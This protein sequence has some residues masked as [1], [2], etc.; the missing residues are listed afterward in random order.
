M[1]KRC[2]RSSSIWHQLVGKKK[3]AVCVS[4]V[5]ISDQWVL[6][7]LKIKGHDKTEMLRLITFTSEPVVWHFPLKKN[8]VS[9]C[10]ASNKKIEKY[11][12]CRSAHVK[13]VLKVR[14]RRTCQNKRTRDNSERRELK[15]L[16][17]SFNCYVISV[18][19]VI[20]W[21]SRSRCNIQKSCSSLSL[22]EKVVGLNF[23]S[24]LYNQPHYRRSLSNVH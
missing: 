15:W 13:R 11:E 1:A 7:D 10:D 2:D 16:G 17:N 3:T 8:N 14:G 24:D 6:E 4:S 5:S 23:K 21:V 9:S 12:V 18:E 19:L 20:L 22:L